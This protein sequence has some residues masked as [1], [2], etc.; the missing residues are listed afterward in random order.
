M[1]KVENNLVHVVNKDRL[2]DHEKGHYSCEA[3]EIELP[4][5]IWPQTIVVAPPIG[6]GRVFERYGITPY[7]VY[8]RQNQGSIVITV[9][10]D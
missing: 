10:N 6:S 5:G 8:Y 9:Y 1:S 2:L 7:A 4:V 3:S